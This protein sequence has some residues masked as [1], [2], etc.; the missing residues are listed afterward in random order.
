MNVLKSHLRITIDTLLKSGTPHREF[1]PATGGGVWVAIG[2]PSDRA[3]VL[4]DTG[5]LP[6]SRWGTAMNQAAISY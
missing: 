3:L 2:E 4:S 6:D 1:D 5:A